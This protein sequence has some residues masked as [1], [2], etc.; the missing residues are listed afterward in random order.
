MS[1]TKREGERERESLTFSLSLSGGVYKEFE[2]GV[3]ASFADWSTRR[4]YLR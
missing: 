3:C 2:V 4:V 1:E